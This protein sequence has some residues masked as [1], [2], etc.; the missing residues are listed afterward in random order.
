M[1][2][3]Y[4]IKL[5]TAN[6]FKEVANFTCSKV[7]TL[8]KKVNELAKKYGVSTKPISSGFDMYGCLTFTNSLSLDN[9]Y[10]LGK[11]NKKLWIFDEDFL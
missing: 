4:V 11:P 6:S 7:S 1:K 8:A 5:E 9:T 10:I 2:Y 3:H